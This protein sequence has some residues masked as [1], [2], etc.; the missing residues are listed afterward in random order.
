MSL[1]RLFIVVGLVGL[2]ALTVLSFLP[3]FLLDQRS[4]EDES[5]GTPGP[6]SYFKTPQTAI[7]TISRLLEERDWKKLSQF[8]D[9]RDNSVDY[10]TLLEG[11][12]FR[13]DSENR[14]LVRPFP[15]EYQYLEIIGTE[16]EDVYEVVVGKMT[17]DN[18]RGALQFFYLKHYP[19]GYRILPNRPSHATPDPAQ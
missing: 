17:E 3:G 16:F 13:I 7:S 4:Y 5:T 9:Q 14:A 15:P 11:S 2:V 1:K 19:E 10:Q 12:Y 8:Y 18:E 6:L